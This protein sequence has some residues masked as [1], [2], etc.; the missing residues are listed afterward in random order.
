MIIADATARLNI[1]AGVDASLTLLSDVEALK[2]WVK[3]ESM[4]PSKGRPEETLGKLLVL[5]EPLAGG[6]RSR[7]LSREMHQLLRA[8]IG[9][10]T[11]LARFFGIESSICRVEVAE[12]LLLPVVVRHIG[13]CFCHTY[14]EAEQTALLTPRKCIQSMFQK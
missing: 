13:L 5:L 6:R 11:F 14:S 3:A 1:P 9:D 2:A 12:M 7:I 8:V 4:W 10:A